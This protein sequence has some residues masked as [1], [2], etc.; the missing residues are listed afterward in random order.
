MNHR[1]A[2]GRNPGLVAAGFVTFLTGLCLAGSLLAALPARADIGPIPVASELSV[3]A[4]PANGAG[5]F[6]T[7][8]LGKASE[9]HT[10]RLR[11]A[12]LVPLTVGDVTLD[13]PRQDPSSPVE[14]T[15]EA[16]SVATDC[17]GAVLL[18]Q[19]SCEV[20]VTFAPL[21]PGFSSGTLR[22]YHDGNTRVL[23]Q[24]L[25]GQ[26]VVGL[27]QAGAFGEL[28]AWGDA[29]FYGDL[30]HVGIESPILA[31]A[32]TPSGEGYWLMEAGGRMHPFGDAPS[33][34]SPTLPADEYAIG[35]AA[36]PTGKGYW[37]VTQTGA[38]YATGDAGF[39]GSAAGTLGDDVGIMDMAATPS[40]KGYWLV[41][42][43]GGV[44]A[45]GDAGFFGSAASLPPRYPIT[46]L[47]PTSTGRGY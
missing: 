26:G 1:C 32:A 34:G 24:P 37:Q 25:Q 29:K 41:D 10:F 19:A 38:V 31:V 12:G 21:R 17:P 4:T 14:S 23:E 3:E 16:F 47:A 15:L 18:P 35:L 27:Y 46:G 9:P 6:P 2:P 20:A 7:L 8:R 28:L 40:G 45:F 11:N 22:V 39:F 44:H 36:T 42:D 13:P 33:L 5:T 30:S 43:A